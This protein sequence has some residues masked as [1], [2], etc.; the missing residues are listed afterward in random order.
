ME[1]GGAAS[2]AVPIR[3]PSDRT[4]HPQGRP[5][6][7]LYSTQEL[8]QDE[9]KLKQHSI[10]VEYAGIYGWAWLPPDGAL[11]EVDQ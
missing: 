4:H 5:A 6:Q 11:V 2:L 10:N 8:Q 3:Y 9:G 1:L 7:P